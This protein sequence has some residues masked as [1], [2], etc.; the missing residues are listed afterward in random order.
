MIEVTF[1]QRSDSRAVAQLVCAMDLEREPDSHVQGFIDRYADAWLADYEDRPTWIAELPNGEPIGLVQT[2]R[3]RRMPSLLRGD[4]SWLQV[5]RVYVTPEKRSRGVGEQMLL[6]MI[7][8]GDE[9]GVDRYQL[10]AVPEARSL[11]GRVGFGGFDG[12][13]MELTR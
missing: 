3:I 9:H 4:A 8:W 1:A 10:K 6:A 5:S 7:S 13:F 11:Y 12:R 2:S